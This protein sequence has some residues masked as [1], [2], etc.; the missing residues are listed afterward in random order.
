MTNFNS[1]QTDLP[2]GKGMK[3]TDKNDQQ[4][5]LGR[6]K[7]KTHK[8][9]H[10][11]ATFYESS[12]VKP[13]NQKQDPFAA[14]EKPPVENKEEKDNLI[15][16]KGFTITTN[17]FK[18]GTT[19]DKVLGGG[20]KK[21]D[22]F[23]SSFKSSEIGDPFPAGPIGEETDPDNNGGYNYESFEILETE[24]EE[25]AFGESNGGLS[26]KQSRRR[27]RASVPDFQETGLHN[28]IRDKI[29]KKYKRKA[30][31]MKPKKS[32]VYRS[33]EPFA[34]EQPDF[35]KDSED[36]FGRQK[37][38]RFYSDEIL[39]NG[40]ESNLKEIQYNQ[41]YGILTKDKVSK[42]ISPREGRGRIETEKRE[43]GFQGSFYDGNKSSQ[44]NLKLQYNGSRQNFHKNEN[45]NQFRTS[46]TSFKKTMYEERSRESSVDEYGY[47]RDDMKERTFA[48]QDMVVKMRTSGM[49]QSFVNAYEREKP[50][51]TQ[52]SG[53][54][55]NKM[56]DTGTRFHLD[57]IGLH[58]FNQKNPLENNRIAER[59]K[60]H[61]QAMLN[62][63][64]SNKRHPNQDERNT[65]WVINLK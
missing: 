22:I 56:R 43:Q 47:R 12:S 6:Q 4:S 57:K 13:K 49:K 16:S 3:F 15:S 37:S 42:S 48:K 62:K 38:G 14:F 58:S 41:N 33:P 25:E 51:K 26:R 29:N 17:D 63:Y 2:Q 5:N 36:S 32:R 59:I 27:G 61:E 24:N 54:S 45:N 39:E 18:Q 30:P 20:F 60:Q 35:C 7:G 9:N 11:S 44:G 10:M 21:I 23:S 19:L 31:S 55:S 34:N 40:S 52:M 50:Q 46:N 8:G 1:K 28:E 64:A 65:N 53:A